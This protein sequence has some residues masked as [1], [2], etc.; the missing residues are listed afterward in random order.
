MVEII[1]NFQEYSMDKDQKL[2]F[3]KIFKKYFNCNAETRDD[4]LIEPF[5]KLGPKIH[6]L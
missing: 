4:I 2:E 3:I 5:K 6:A 1:D